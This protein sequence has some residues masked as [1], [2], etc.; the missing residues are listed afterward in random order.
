MGPTAMAYEGSMGEAGSPIPYPGKV[1]SPVCDA[2][3]Q[4]MQGKL[5]A[6]A[7]WG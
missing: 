4:S 2:G 7:G 5:P 6:G 1:S 3:D